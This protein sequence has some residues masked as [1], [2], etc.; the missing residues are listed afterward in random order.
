MEI[1][2]GEHHHHP[3][4]YFPTPY[5]YN[6]N[7]P[8]KIFHFVKPLSLFEKVNGNDFE[9]DRTNLRSKIV[10]IDYLI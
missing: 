7:L 6:N 10:K 5:C 4:L 9:T 3:F 8:Q 2:R 1:K